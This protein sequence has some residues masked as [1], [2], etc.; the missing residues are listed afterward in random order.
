MPQPTMVETLMDR[1][2][3]YGNL[4]KVAIRFAVSSGNR[5]EFDAAE[6][7]AR[8]AVTLARTALDR[9]AEITTHGRV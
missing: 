6:Q 2:A 3:Y 7:Y 9:V 1:A 4:S 8:M 5:A